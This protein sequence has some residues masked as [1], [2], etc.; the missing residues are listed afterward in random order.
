MQPRISPSMTISLDNFHSVASKA[1]LTHCLSSKL[2]LAAEMSGYCNANGMAET[3]V[4]NISSIDSSVRIELV[5]VCRHWS[6]LC[7]PPRSRYS[8]AFSDS[9]IFC[10]VIS[11]SLPR[12]PRKSPCASIIGTPLVDNHTSSPSFRRFTFMNDSNGRRS[13]SNSIAVALSA[14]RSSGRK[15]S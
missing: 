1:S 10:R 9:S 15:S 5:M 11:I 3:T 8:F 6:S 4:S 13:S 7:R 2:R 14:S 12:Y